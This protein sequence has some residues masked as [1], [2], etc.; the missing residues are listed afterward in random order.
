M[1]MHLTFAFAST[2]LENKSCFYH[3][4]LQK[5]TPDVTLDN[6]HTKICEA[7]EP[8]GPYR[9]WGSYWCLNHKNK[10]PTKS[11]MLVADREVTS[12]F[13]IFYL[14]AEPSICLFQSHYFVCLCVRGRAV[15]VL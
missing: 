6:M 8:A 10:V 13:L 3:R 11:S 7:F 14:N 12:D 15:N 1:C 9:W 2:N 5:Q 4:F